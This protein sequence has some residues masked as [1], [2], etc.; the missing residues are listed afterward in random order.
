MCSHASLPTLAKCTKCGRGF[1]TIPKPGA[2]LALAEQPE[3][4][5]VTYSGPRRGDSQRSGILHAQ[6]QP[7]VVED[8]MV[9]NAVRT[10]NA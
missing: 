2:V 5:S 4:A 3:G 9:F 6:S 10:N 7:I 8:G 1:I